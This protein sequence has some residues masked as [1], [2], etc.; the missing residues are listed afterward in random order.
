MKTLFENVSILLRK[1]NKYEVLEHAYLG[2][3]GKYI[4]YIGKD[5]PK[6]NYD[7]KKDFKKIKK[8]LDKAKEKD[9][10]NNKKKSKN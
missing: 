8:E 9:E 2:V 1:N 6:E 7:V 5:S 3:D 10:T 4:C